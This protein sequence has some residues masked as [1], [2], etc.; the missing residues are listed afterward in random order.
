[1]VHMNKAVWLSFDLGIKGDYEGMYRWLDARDGVECGDS[2]AFLELGAKSSLPEEIRDSLKAEV[3]VDS[4]TRIYMV[5]R[6][7]KRTRGKFLFGRRK[8]PPWAGY[9]PLAE[10]NVSDE[11]EDVR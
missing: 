9:A 3:E 2:L 11:D 4:K 7:G 6:D 1:M 8:A 5:W 10:A